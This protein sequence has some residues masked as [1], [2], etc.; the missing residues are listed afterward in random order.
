MIS[1]DARLAFTLLHHGVRE[2]ASDNAR[3]FE[4]LGFERVW[5]P[6]TR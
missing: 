5:N 6:I 2:L 4:G 1:V 3:D